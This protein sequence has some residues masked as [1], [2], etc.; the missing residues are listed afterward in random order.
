M[1]KHHYSITINAPVSKVRDT[2]LGDTGYRKWTSAFNPAGSRYEG[3]RSEWSKI[4]FLGPDPEHPERVGG[5]YSEIAANRAH[6]YISIRHLGEV[7]PDGSIK[8]NAE[9]A[10]AYENYSF[11][12]KDGST[13]VTVDIDM[14][15]DF[16]DYMNEARPKALQTLKDL[17]EQQ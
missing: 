2:M 13:T 5:M 15:E 11:S 16:I 10:D 12:K 4:R 14:T 3:D 1:L 7:G 9:R 17:C 6:E 8:E